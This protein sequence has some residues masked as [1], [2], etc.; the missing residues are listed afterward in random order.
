MFLTQSAFSEQKVPNSQE[1]Q[2]KQC[3]GSLSHRRLLP[4]FTLFLKQAMGK[5]PS[6]KR[7]LKWHAAT[8]N[9]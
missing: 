6:I 2:N 8:A 5:T 9:V 3:A 1:Y 4:T 7:Q